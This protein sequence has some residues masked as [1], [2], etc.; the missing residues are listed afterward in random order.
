MVGLNRNL[1]KGVL[2]LGMVAL[3]IGAVFIGQGIAKNNMIK[4]AMQVE[5]ITY[6][7]AEEI[8]GFI[9]TATEAELMASVLREHRMDIGVYSE[10]DREDPKRDTILKAMTMENTLNLAQLGYGV[11][12]VVIVSGI[13]MVIIGIAVSGT[14]LVLYRLGDKVL[15]G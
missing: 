11:V 14:G 10:L 6:G 2:L 15:L 9:D 5:Q 1:G 4:E 12:T 8:N 3:V 13:F 7:G